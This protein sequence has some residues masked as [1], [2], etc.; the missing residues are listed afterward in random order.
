MAGG[1]E[2]LIALQRR[3]L[4]PLLAL[5]PDPPVT[6]LH[7]LTMGPPVAL[8]PPGLNFAEIR[9]LK[10]Y[11]TRPPSTKH[12]SNP[13]EGAASS[14]DAVQTPPVVPSDQ[15]SLKDCPVVIH[16]DTLWGTVAETVPEVSRDT[17]SMPPLLPA[18]SEPIPA[19]PPAGL[20]PGDS[21]HTTF[22]LPEQSQQII[23][24][25]VQQ[26]LAA[27]F[28]PPSRAVLVASGVPAS[29]SEACHEESL[30][31]E[32]PASPVSTTGSQVSSSAEIELYD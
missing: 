14:R 9:F 7:D 22:L 32:A 13:K 21:Q 10:S 26:P 31:V 11:V 19:Q 17:A 4:C 6:A 8:F 12:Q 18:S 29:H 5:Q 1:Q 20:D 15:A 24:A 30:D 3:A 2:L 16:L 28:R 25:A 27:Q 23:A